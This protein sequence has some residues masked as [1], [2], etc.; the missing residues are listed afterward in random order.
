MK[1]R[2]FLLNS[3]RLSAGSVLINKIP[4]STF[5]TPM[6]LPLLCEGIEERMM[7]IVFLD[8]G[9]DGL[10]TIIPVEIYDTYFGLRPDI[11]IPETG[12]GAYIPLDGTLPL[13]D[14]VGL[15]PSMTAFKTMYDNGLASLVQ[16]VGYPDSNGSHFKSTDLWLTGGD[17]T[18]AYFNIG[19][20]WMG[21]FLQTVFPGLNGNPTEANP[22]P[23]GI[24]LGDTKPS[25]GFYDTLGKFQ[26]A[27]LSQ[28]DPG[29]LFTQILGVGTPNQ[30]FF[31][32]SDY[33]EEMQYIMAIEN[34]VSVYAQR[35]SDTFN[36]GVNDPGAGYNASFLANQLMTVAR[37]ISGGCRSKVFLVRTGGFDTHADQVQA[38]STHT[39]W[40]ADL[41]TNVFDSIKA[42]HD[43]LTAQGM[44]HLV[45]TTTFSEFGRKVVQNGSFGTDHGNL[46]PMFLFGN[47]IEPGVHGT[48]L[49]LTDVTNQGTVPDSQMQHDYRS[50]YRTIIQDWL[51][52]SS[53]ALEGTQLD[54]WPAIP[55][56]VKPAYAVDGTCLFDHYITQSVVRA[57]IFLEGFYDQSTGIM[58]T[59]LSDQGMLPLQQPYDVAPYNYSGTEILTEIPDNVVDWL[60][61][62]LRDKNDVNIVL[63][64]RA[65][66]LRRDGQ[67]IGLNGGLGVAFDNLL[68]DSYYIAIYHRSHIA[69]VS[70][71]AVDL[72]DVSS[73]YDFTAD[74]SA[75]L[76]TGQL[77]E[78]NGVYALFAGDYNGS[79]IAD[80]QDFDAWQTESSGVGGYRTSDA[81]GNGIVNNLDYNLWKR[82]E[83][84]AGHG[85][86]QQ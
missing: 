8:G 56:M 58:R 69:V 60:L 32:Q 31:P 16:G 12:T 2:D 64:R 26:A 4:M 5:A 59:T 48:N 51:G 49:D 44:D 50:V 85:V 41:L 73:V 15:H 81:D 20:G 18:E 75:A 22:D 76:G 27:N 10:N 57:R 37:L 80:A 86:I 46:A 9:N 74:G 52:G 53:S 24:Q 55:G 14:Q 36:A 67:V 65:A 13:A 43:D 6:M 77:K 17:G 61:V 63:G 45:L 33:G 84:Q 35:I 83:N 11:A 40:H 62:E 39:G 28:Q 42:F 25:I 78:I 29:G 68:P 66:L 3:A 7:V 19:S 21:R 1:R 82:N 79:G 38:G 23:L 30:G 72:L 54:A 34:S 71:G 47:G 70:N